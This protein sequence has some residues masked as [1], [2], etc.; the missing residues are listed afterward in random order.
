MKLIQVLIL[1]VC[2][3]L[4]TAIVGLTKPQ[5]GLA[6]AEATSDVFVD[7]GQELGITS[8]SYDVALGDLDGDTDLDAFVANYLDGNEVWRNNGSAFFS[9]PALTEEKLVV[10]G[11]D[12]KVHCLNRKTGKKIWDFQTRG[13]VDASP[14]ICGEKVIIGSLDGRIYILKLADGS[15]IWTYDIGEGISA[16]AAVARG[17]LLIGSE[18]GTLYIFGE[19]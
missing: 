10:G 12:K 4:S 18:D 11:R 5:F 16:A 17:K 8:S 2:I 3:L 19:K 7:S 1:V 13:D 9:T 6:A 14:L 15:K